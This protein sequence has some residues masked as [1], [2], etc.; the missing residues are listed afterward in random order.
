MFDATKIINNFNL[1]VATRRQLPLFTLSSI[2]LCYVVFLKNK[3][4]KCKYSAVGGWGDVS[5]FVSLMNE[6]EIVEQMTLKLRKSNLVKE[7]YVSVIYK[8]LIKFRKD[9]FVLKNESFKE[10]RDVVALLRLLIEKYGIYLTMIGNLNCLWR[11]VGDNKSNKF[12]LSE[13]NYFARVRGEVAGVYPEMEIVLTRLCG[14]LGNRLKVD[15]DL[16]RYFTNSEFVKFLNS[17]F[18]ISNKLI[19]EL[20]KRR[21]GYFYLYYSDKEVVLTDK[22]KINKI[23]KLILDK[24]KKG[25]SQ[26]NGVPVYGGKISASVFNFDG[27]IVG[28]L[29]RK[30]VLVTYMTHPKDI[31]LI[32]K[33]S[34]IITDEG[35]VLC[36]AAI[37]ARELKKPCIIGVKA[38]TELLRTGMK[39][40]LD[41]DKGL[42]KIIS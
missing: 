22:R 26:L 24:E 7:R 36:H 1:K 34:G 8:D 4:F 3:Y 42:V 32:K 33:S 17:N 16:F 10:E 20:K 41:A 30:F 39:V 28:K 31:A 15:G 13:I 9:F 37:V 18:K 23:K 19:N 11:Y 27:K 14:L 5:G 6:N 21:S 25:E 35:G 2:A 40:K 38:A 29:P 12:N